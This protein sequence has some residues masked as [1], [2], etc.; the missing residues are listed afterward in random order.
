MVVL[1]QK[2]WENMFSALQWDGFRSSSR[3]NGNCYLQCWAFKY[4]EYKIGYTQVSGEMSGRY[5]AQT[6]KG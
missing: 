1:Q 5:E 3:F 6:D 4:F 2:C